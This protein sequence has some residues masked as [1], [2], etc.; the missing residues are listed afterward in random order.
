MYTNIGPFVQIVA[1]LWT[2]T[3]RYK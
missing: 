2:H 1:S 3:R